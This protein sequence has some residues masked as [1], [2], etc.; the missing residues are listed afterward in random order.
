[1]E[2]ELEKA[3]GKWMS[4]KEKRHQARKEYL[5]DF[6][7]DVLSGDKERDARMKKKDKK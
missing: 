2:V 7:N 3:Q 5:L 6:L 4:L 1:M